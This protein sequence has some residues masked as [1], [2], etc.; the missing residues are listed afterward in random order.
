M[1][2]ACCDA[3]IIMPHYGAADLILSDCLSSPYL[4]LIDTLLD[5]SESARKDFYVR[6]GSV[7]ITIFEGR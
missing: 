4:Y 1:E 3:P 2:A 5:D 6:L 7:D